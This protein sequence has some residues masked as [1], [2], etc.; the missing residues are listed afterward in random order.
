MKKYLIIALIVSIGIIVT[1]QSRMSSL[2]KEHDRIY[3]NY[4]E[5]V[6]GL[7]KSLTL[8]K[9]ELKDYIKE[10]K[11]LDSLL[12]A[13]KI[14]PAKIKYITRVEH[15]YITD[16]IRVKIGDSSPN[17]DSIFPFEYNNGCLFFDGELEVK[18][19]KLTLNSVEYNDNQT[20]IVYLKKKK[21]GRKFLFVFPIK[22]QYIELHTHSECGENRVEQLNINK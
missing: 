21:T 13:E 16:T 22:K 3:N 10:N 18:T 20:H 1:L 4:Q 9:Q 6:E 17:N 7:N 11:K 14:K 5:Q 2:K 8:T 12:K 19:P 15:H